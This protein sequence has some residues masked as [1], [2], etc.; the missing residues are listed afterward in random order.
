MKNHDKLGSIDETFATFNGFCLSGVGWG[1]GGVGGWVNPLKTKV[2]DE[3][4][5]SDNVERSSKD[6]WKV[7]ADVKANKN[8]KKWKI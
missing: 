4:L 1:G 3:N 2:Y 7:P 6:L 8:N 5:F